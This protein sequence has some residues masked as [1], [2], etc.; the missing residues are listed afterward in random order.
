MSAQDKGKLN[1]GDC[2]VRFA[3]LGAHESPYHPIDMQLARYDRKRYS[4]IGRPSE[5]A[6]AVAQGRQVKEFS[7]V[8]IKCE[9]GKGI[10][11]HGHATSEVFIVMS[12]RWKIVGGAAGEHEVE[13][14][15]WD[16]ISVPPDLMHGAV[17][18]S[19]EDGWLMA[20]NAGQAGAK[21]AWA[22]ELLAEIRAQGKH[23]AESETPGLR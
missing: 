4:V 8:Y 11:A 21:I 12:G 18:V 9:P 13:L 23:A 6:G 14:G 17:N 7:V 1:I 20:I 2:I 5:Q 19:D 3:E 15:P 22:P 16:V 10:G